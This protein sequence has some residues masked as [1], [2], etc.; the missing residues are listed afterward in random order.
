MLMIKCGDFRTNYASDMA[1]FNTDFARYCLVIF[2]VLLMLF[3]LVSTNYWLDV[4]NRIGIAII[5]AIGLNILTGYTGQISMGNAAFLAVGAY[6]TGWLANHAGLPLLITIPMS[7]LIT[8]A[9]GMIFGI[10]SLRLRGLF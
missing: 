2:L 9:V 8:A 5:G 6:S 1:V 4:V 10:P 7:G 3:P